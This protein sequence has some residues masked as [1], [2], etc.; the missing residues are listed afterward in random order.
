MSGALF[1]SGTAAYTIL[2]PIW[3]YLADHGLV[4]KTKI[5]VGGPIFIIIGFSLLGPL[6]FLPYEKYGPKSGKHF[7]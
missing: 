5:L 3:G 4:S 2:A 6:P 7:K 1:S